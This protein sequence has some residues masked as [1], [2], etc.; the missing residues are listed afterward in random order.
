MSAL[1]ESVAQ[2][3]IDALLQRLRDQGYA[4]LVVPRTLSG[5][6]RVVALAPDGTPREIV[7]DPLLGEFRRD[8][9]KA[10]NWG[11]APRLP[12]RSSGLDRPK[13]AEARYGSGSTGKHPR[14]KGGNSGGT[15]PR[16][17]GTPRLHLRW[18]QVAL[19]S[20]LP[21]RVVERGPTACKSEE[22]CAIRGPEHVAGA[23][24]VIGRRR[25]DTDWHSWPKAR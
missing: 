5:R 23:S 14:P 8:N 1:S 17:L 22:K 4:V 18:V 7:F 25:C 3:P 6:I 2:P 12:D 21:K 24:A 15:W 9:S 19:S 16:K 20:A 10:A 13:V 11:V